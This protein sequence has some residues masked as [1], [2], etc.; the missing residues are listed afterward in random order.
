QIPANIFC[1]SPNSLKQI[2]Y[3]CRMALKSKLSFMVSF[4]VA[5]C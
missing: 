2:P 5:V 4:L 3:L 1:C